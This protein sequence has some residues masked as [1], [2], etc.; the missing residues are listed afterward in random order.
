MMSFIT[1]V[2]FTLC[3]LAPWLLLGMG[4][5]GLLH[6]ALPA[7]FVRQKL[8][9]FSGVLKAVAIGVPLPLCSCGVIPAGI[10]LKKDGAS[11]G[12]AVGFLIS[13]PQTGVDSILVS[14]SFFGWPF[15]VFKLVTAAVMGIVGG[16]WI[17]RKSIESSVL[18]LE[19]NAA[20]NTAHS[21]AGHTHAD[22]A[23][24]QKSWSQLLPHAIDMLR[25]IWVWLVVGIVISALIN[26]FDIAPLTDRINQWGLLPAML[27]VLLFS[28]PL[29]V[30]ATAS[31]PIA[32]ALVSSG[33]PPA[34][35]LVFLMAG[36]ATNVATMGAIRSNL[37]TR[38]LAIYLLTIV[39]GSMGAAYL[40]D[41]LVSVT[42]T[43]GIAHV[44]NVTA[45]WAQLSAVIV[46]GLIA[47]FVWEKAK[48]WTKPRNLSS[49]SSS[50]TIAID[51]MSCGNCV[52]KLETLIGKQSGVDS[53]HVSLADGR[54]IVVGDFDLESLKQKI[55]KSG[56]VPH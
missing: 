55:L 20:K 25:S 2:W 16:V 37:G 39:V 53:V 34:V 14:A 36:P 49:E 1:A 43:A 9:G 21:N 19:S 47:M 44:H 13:T 31:V 52:Q 42:T 41:S 17:D 51:G 22:S 7:K 56:F 4:L 38:A 30:C 33:L 50:Q 48:R 3:E 10:G 29:Y 8:R 24:D 15:A 32:A 40:F 45:W 26:Q 28:I 18:P 54:A 12:A 11:S 6:V 23:T 35:A 46:L 5:S 27:L